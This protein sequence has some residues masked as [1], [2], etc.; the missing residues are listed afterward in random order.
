M[1]ILV[2]GGCGY[3]GSHTCC[4]LLDNNYEVVIVDNLANSNRYITKKIEK[5]TG[6]SVKLYENDL[7]DK[8]A[9]R[10]IFSENDIVAVIHLAGK[11]GIEE[12]NDKAIEF[13]NDNVAA[14]IALLEVMN[15]FGCKKLVF[16]STAM[17]YGSEYTTKIT[18]EDEISP[19]NI[20]GETKAMC[21]MILQDIY[22]QD[23]TWSISI[24]RHFNPAGAHHSGLLG[25]NLE[26]DI[27]DL[28][29]R[30]V[31]VAIGKIPELTIFGNSYDTED[32]TGRRDFTHISDISRAHV[33]AIEKVLSTR[34]FDCYNLGTGYSH[35][36]IDVIKIFE[37]VNDVK[38]KYKIEERRN[39][40][41]PICYANPDYTARKLGWEAHKDLGDICTDSYKYALKEYA[42][43]E[44]QEEI[45]DKEEIEKF[46]E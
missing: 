3:L 9:L 25:E 40:D 4:E 6:K 42:N 32:G 19:E 44:E 20:F 36:V 38:I 1:K 24:L 31:K 30:I 45:E 41:V 7:C 14:T 34:E 23:N 5:I 8:V 27:S 43:Q 35:S 2:T 21:E 28:I 17:V 11:K 12:P 15:E 39:G 26:S 22:Y 29:P 13:Y 37:K 10:K 16:G 33:K 46:E 18:E